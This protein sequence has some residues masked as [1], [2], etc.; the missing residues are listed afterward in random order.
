MN[1]SR[2]HYTLELYINNSVDN[3]ETEYY[4]H[5]ESVVRLEMTESILTLLP[6]IELSFLDKGNVV[7]AFPVLD[8][9]ILHIRLSPPFDTDELEINAKFTI[10]SFKVLGVARNEGTL[11]NL[12]GYLATDNMF[13]PYRR[14]SRSGSS[15]QI[16]QSIANDVGLEFNSNTSGNE[17][18]YWYQDS[19]NY[20][21]LKYVADRSYVANDGVF[22][23]GD[24]SGALNYMSYKAVNALDVKFQARYNTDV[25]YSEIIADG[26]KEFMYYDNYDIVNNAEPYNNISNYGGSWSHYNLNEYVSEDINSFDSVTDLTDRRESYIGDSVFSIGSGIIAE[27]NLRNTMFRGKVQNSFA[28]YHLFTNNIYLN[29]LNTTDVKLLDKVHLQVGSTSDF[30]GIAE[31]Y[32]G[33]YLVTSISHSVIK[34]GFPGYSKRVLVCR[35]GINKSEIKTDYSGM[36]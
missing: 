18:T 10:S 35:N 14:T 23:Y 30:N 9:D 25:F 11:V 26:D 5:Q 17:S 4:I 15:D 36:V 24:L 34:D 20:G 1:S 31:P 3:E 28:K 7:N 33:E 21:F 13:A 2:Q 6:K 32:S 8:K 12:S 27:P 29:I 19:N 16:I 22:V